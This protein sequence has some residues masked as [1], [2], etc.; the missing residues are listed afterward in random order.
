MPI[1]RSSQ[2]STTTR[3]ERATMP[4][5]SSAAIVAQ[6]TA[7]LHRRERRGRPLRDGHERQR[8]PR[9]HESQRGPGHQ[10]DG[11]QRG[12]LER[13]P[14]RELTRRQAERPQQR[15]FGH[16]LP[17]GDRGADDEP[18]D[19]EQA[20]G[21]DADA[22]DAD[23]P[24]R[25]RVGRE[26]LVALDQAHDRAAAERR[27]AQ[28]IDGRLALRRVEREPPFLRRSRRRRCLRTAAVPASGSP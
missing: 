8:D 11:G 12:V 21:H 24:E 10:A 17:G 1:R 22:Q 6:G 27:V 19:G 2:A 13:Q 3:R 5:A 23:D 14:A 26:R 20:G 15:E 4:I 25:D 28:A 9:D 16:A 18:D 7:H